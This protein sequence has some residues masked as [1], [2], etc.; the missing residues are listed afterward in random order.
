MDMAIIFMIVASI[1]PFLYLHMKKYVFAGVQ[2]ILLIGMWIYFVQAINPAT[3][4]A[5][6]SILWFAFYFCLVISEIA[7]IMFAIYLAKKI[8]QELREKAKNPRKETLT[9]L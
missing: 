5:N 4:P 7:Y 8:Q 1:A 9:D 3:V 6:F 2:I